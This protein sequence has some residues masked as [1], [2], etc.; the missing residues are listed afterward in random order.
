MRETTSLV[1]LHPSTRPPFGTPLSTHATIHTTY[2]QHNWCEVIYVHF[3][4]IHK[5]C[6]NGQLLYIF[7]VGQWLHMIHKETVQG[8]SKW[9][10]ARYYYKAMSKTNYSIHFVHNS[11]RVCQW[12]KIFSWFIPIHYITII[13]IYTN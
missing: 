9:A 1:P 4:G 11:N 2:V 8:L 13:S 10:K 7:T 6:N 5:Q 12:G 3:Y